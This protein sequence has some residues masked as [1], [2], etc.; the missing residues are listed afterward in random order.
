MS[1]KNTGMLY[2]ALA[3]IFWS[4]AGAVVKYIPWH[5]LSI[6]CVR[7]VA[8]AV[9]IAFLQRRVRVKLTGATVL[10]AVCMLG[11]TI[12]FMF[13]NKTTSAANAIVLQ[14][15]AP[16]YVLIAT[17]IL[18]KSRFKPLDIFAVLLTLA[19]I[20]L[21]FV[22]HLGQGALLGDVLALL[23]GVTFAG[24]FFFN[25]LPSANPQDASLLGCAIAVLLVPVL[26]F[27]KQVVTGGWMPWVLAILMGMLQLGLAYFFFA[28]GVQQT[29]AVT[30]S[31]IC[32]AEPILNP[33]WVFLLLQ[34]RPGAL[35][36]VGGAIVV[37][38]ICVY[39]V[40]SAKKA[41]AADS[42]A[43]Q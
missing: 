22:D 6:S 37:A 26:F 7:G 1:K 30:S 23:S 21:F 43:T 10:A 29:G 12:L 11:T 17:T 5:P 33:I 9:A 18:K 28:K 25:G 32:T 15:T 14:Y 34:E 24:V 4:F 8:A 38:T 40:I 39:N 3:A 13:A 2:V 36:L 31:I 35:S 16:V 19:G 42:T 27:D 41:P 20:V